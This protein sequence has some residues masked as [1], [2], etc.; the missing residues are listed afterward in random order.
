MGG[1]P[2]GRPEPRRQ[3]SEIGRQRSEEAMTCGFRV[4]PIPAG[5][6]EIAPEAWTPNVG[7]SSARVG[8][9]RRRGAGDVFDQQWDARL[10]TVV[11]RNVDRVK[12]RRFE[13]QV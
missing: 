12:P 6:P 3:T 5:M 8:S 9:L 7:E 10:R 2:V 11:Q 1:L 13:F 4:A